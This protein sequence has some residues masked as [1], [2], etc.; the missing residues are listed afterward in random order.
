MSVVALI[1]ARGG[2]KRIRQKNL[3]VAGGHPLV[4]WSV[5]AAIE[6]QTVSHVYVTTDS[7]DIAAVAEDYGARIIRRPEAISGDGAAIESAISHALPDFPVDWWSVVLL[8]P[9]SPLRWADKIDAAVHLLRAEGRPD[10]VVGVV[11][12]PGCHFTWGALGPRY[13]SRPRTQDLQVWRETGALYAF[14]RRSWM[15]THNRVGALPTTLELSQAE[16]WDI[17]TEWELEVADTELWRHQL[18]RNPRIP[19]PIPAIEVHA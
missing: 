15:H 14:T 4:A 5:R 2:S 9:T 18:R 12:D 6:S 11:R 3:R 7:D 8:Q 19:W 16:G 1:P 10:S 17:D 13:A